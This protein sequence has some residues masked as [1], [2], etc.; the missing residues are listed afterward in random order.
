MKSILPTCLIVGVAC[1]GW[2]LKA[3]ARPF[4]PEQFF[5]GRTKSQGEFHIVG[6]E[7]TFHTAGVGATRRGMLWLRQEITF[8]DGKR[9]LRQWEL[10]RLP[11]NRYEGHISD[12]V[13]PVRGDLHGDTLHLRY[14][15]KAGQGGTFHSF[16]VEQWLTLQPDGRTLEIRAAFRKLG[17]RIGS[18]KETTRKVGPR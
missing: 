17:L 16:A 3:E 1:I 7:G 10:R 13:G 14:A 11:G 4:E 8:G 9:Q 2:H 15:L 12:G 18:L 5:A 6:K